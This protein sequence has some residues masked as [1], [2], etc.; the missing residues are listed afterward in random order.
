MITAKQY[1]PWALIAGGSEGVAASF[2]H[3][4]ADVGLNLVLVARRPEPLDKLSR[5][6]RAKSKVEVRTLSLDLKQ[7]DMLERIGEITDDIEIGLLI[8]NA[9]DTGRMTG[10]FLDRTLEDVLAAVQVTAIGQT[11]LAHH[12]GSRMA[13]RGRGGIILVGS[14]S[15][16]AGM[17]GVA[18]YCASKAFSQILAEAL[19]GE[20]K[21]RGI[22]VL[23]LVLGFTDT[24]ARARSGVPLTETPGMPVIA[25][26]DVAQQALDNLAE[27]GP[28]YVPPAY[29][30]M[31][32]YL[33]A[34]PRRQL[35]ER[36]RGA[37]PQRKAP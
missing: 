16:N 29:A 20:L 30:Q 25:A 28:V 35:S 15:G 18:T 21:P 36:M 19:W 13:A 17:P 1:G 32:Q 14:L 11:A 23:S 12:F 7:P 37:A 22:D 5:E 9:G 2:A 24:P 8:F 6:V 31:F 27:G 33:C 4:L 34:T 10:P 26:D 3:K